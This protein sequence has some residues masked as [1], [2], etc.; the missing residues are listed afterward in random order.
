MEVRIV[1]LKTINGCD[2][3]QEVGRRKDGKVGRCGLQ[4]IELKAWD[5]VP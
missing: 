3:Q 2:T 4:C 5:N 1:R